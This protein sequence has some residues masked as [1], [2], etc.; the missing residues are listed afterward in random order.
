[1]RYFLFPLVLGLILVAALNLYVDSRGSWWRTKSNFTENWN[2]DQAWVIPIGMDERKPRIQQIGMLSKIDTLALGSSRVFNL[3]ASMLPANAKFY[4]ASVAGATI[5]DFVVMWEKFKQQGNI[6]K[7]LIIYVDTWGFNKNTWQKYRWISNLPL[8]ID[9]LKD[10]GDKYD[11]SSNVK[12]AALS[13]WLSGSFY[14]FSD[15]FS[16][17][18]LKFSFQELNIRRKN[19]TVKTNYISSL[20]DRPMDFPAWKNDG[21]YLFSQES[22]KPK[23]LEKINEI[24]RNTGLGGMYMYLMDWET[25]DIAI[26][27]LDYLLADTEKYGVEVFLVQPPFQHETFKILN[28]NSSYKKIPEIYENIMNSI[29]KS[30]PKVTYC[31]A[32]NPETISCNPTEFMDSAHTLKPCAQKVIN[33][34]LAKVPLW[35]KKNNVH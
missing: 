34:C 29:L 12:I 19:G 5:W 15:L 9:F 2:N 23:T 11:K 7:H 24:G 32:S 10:G 17:A 13:E 3:D 4:N 25:N 8:V 20:K 1:M 16:P 22:I 33:Y 27:L 28:N 31:N 30:H 6:P 21:S 26:N 14:E 35:Y 18:V